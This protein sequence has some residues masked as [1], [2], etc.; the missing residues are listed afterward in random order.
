MNLNNLTTNLP[1]IG[2]IGGISLFYNQCKSFLFRIFRFFIKKREISMDFAQSFYSE[3]EN[4]GYFFKWDD[5]DL[6]Y[7]SLFCKKENHFVACLFKC[8][9]TEIFLYKYFIPVILRG[10]EG[11]FFTVSYLKFTFSFNS[12]LEKAVK[13]Y[14]EE[15]I[16]ISHDF[17]DRVHLMQGRFRIETISGSSLKINRFKNNDDVNSEL[18]RS[19]E[20]PQ[21]GN[22]VSEKSNGLFKIQECLNKKM[23]DRFF[24]INNEI[25]EYSI[26]AHVMKEKNKYQFTK[27]GEYVLDQ[28]QKWLKS[29]KWYEE[30]NISFRRGILLYGESGVGKSSLICEIAKYFGIPIFI[31]D[32]S[33]M[34]N[35]EFERKLSILEIGT[36]IILF[37]DFD[38]IF[39]KRENL[40]KTN[41]FSGIS[42]DYFL[43]KLSGVN[44]ISNK[45]I[46]ITTNYPEKLD[47]ALLRPGRIDEMIQLVSLNIDEKRKMAKVFL[48]E[49]YELIEKCLE[50]GKNFSTAQF[51]NLLTQ[52]ALALLWN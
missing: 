10:I 13:K 41:N 27:Q 45:F 16:S 48:G 12:F 18:K 33:N 44:S 5:F 37:E 47:E 21:S 23:T 51:E 9:G 39:N 20:E 1:F 22:S 52:K 24:G 36:G 25:E 42:F 14:Q 15:V 50:E 43:N 2:I 38:N 11:K 19:F 7:N 34:D 40:C 8:Y 3:I 26:F 17:D 29:K 49:N 31:F 32:L 28:V 6:R 30:R 46:F 35:Q 4:Q